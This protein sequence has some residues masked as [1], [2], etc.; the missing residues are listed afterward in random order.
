MINLHFILLL[1]FH[2]AYGLLKFCL[3]F[4][5]LSINIVVVQKKMTQTCMGVFYV[6]FLYDVHFS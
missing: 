2:D 5:C 1:A 4:I 3:Y 6:F